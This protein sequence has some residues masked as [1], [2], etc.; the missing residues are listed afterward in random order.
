MPNIDGN[1]CVQEDSVII[2]H[3]DDRRKF[4]DQENRGTES[5]VDVTDGVPAEEG[6]ALA[7]LLKRL[8]EQLQPGPRL[9]GR[10]DGLAGISPDPVD[11]LHD[12]H[13]LAD[14]LVVV[15]EDGDLLVHRVGSQKQLALLPELL[16]QE[17]VLHPLQNLVVDVDGP[18]AVEGALVGVGRQDGVAGISPGPVDVL[19]DDH[20]LADGLVVVEEDGDLLVHRV[21]SQKQLAL[22]PELLR[23]ELVLHPLQGSAGKMARPA[24]GQASST[25]STMIIDSQMGLPWWRRTGIFLYTGLDLRSSSLFSPDFSCR[26]SYSTPFR[27]RATLGRSTN[28]LGHAPISL[29]S[30]AAAAI[31]FFFFFFFFFFSLLRYER[32]QRLG[33]VPIYNKG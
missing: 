28:G 8:L 29:T 2:I 10:Q 9:V 19:H 1:H 20:R 14:G 25:Y 12:D 4:I 31:A 26:N 27:F 30:P 3:V 32:Q 16:L 18:E 23:Q 22:L 6:F 13:R 11:V 7:Q 17:L 24:P 15:E 33:F 5:D 21:G